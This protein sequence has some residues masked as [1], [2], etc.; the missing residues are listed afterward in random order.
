VDRGVVRERRHAAG[1][2]LGLRIAAGS[3]PNLADLE[4]GG[5]GPVI[6]DPLNSSQTTTLAKF[7]SQGNLL[8]TGI[9]AI[10]GVCDKFFEAATPPGGETPVDTLSP[11]QNIAASPWHQAQELF[12]A[13]RFLSSRLTRSGYVTVG[14]GFT[15]C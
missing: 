6:Q 11:A 15:G 5:L 2:D 4:T 14:N 13:L 3:V 7:N 10:P 12:A 1:Q 9:T 8:S